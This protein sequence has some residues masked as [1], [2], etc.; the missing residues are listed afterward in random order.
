M[1]E[2]QRAH[3]LN[4]KQTLSSEDGQKNVSETFPHWLGGLITATL[5]IESSGS[6]VF[7]QFFYIYFTVPANRRKEAPLHAFG[8][9]IFTLTETLRFIFRIQSTLCKFAFCW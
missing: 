7:C 9:D 3:P 6:K 5:S 8:G 1:T 4:S 2:V